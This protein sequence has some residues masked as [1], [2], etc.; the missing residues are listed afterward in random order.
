MEPNPNDSCDLPPL[1]RSDDHKED[2]AT[3]SGPFDLQLTTWR[4]LNSLVSFD[5][6]PLP[7]D[8]LFRSVP[9]DEELCR[10]GPTLVADYLNFDVS[11]KTD[12][13]PDVMTTM[14]S[15]LNSSTTSEPP[16]PKG[17]YVEPNYHATLSSFRLPMDA[18]TAVQHFLRSQSIDFYDC[19]AKYKLNCAAYFEGAKIPFKVR[20]YTISTPLKRYVI[21]F[22]RRSGN[23]LRFGEIY[24][25]AM[26]SL[27]DEGLLSEGF[28]VPPEDLPCLSSVPRPTLHLDKAPATIS[29]LLQMASSSYEDV[30]C[31]AL[32][33][34]SEISTEQALR[35]PQQILND[36]VLEAF[37]AYSN[38]EIEDARRCAVT[39]MANLTE[40]CDVLAK[41]FCHTL[42]ARGL[43]E[44]FCHDICK[45]DEIFTPQIMRETSRLLVNIAQ[46]VGARM[47]DGLDR[48]AATEA[49]GKLNL[50]AD[51]AVRKYAE[52]IGQLMRAPVAV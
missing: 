34:L 29:I 7:D 9:G 8:L 14:Y 39:G 45:S 25:L 44:Q 35:Q 32:R 12:S 2:D 18:L 4:S 5:G 31:E 1:S 26:L 43:V 23:T 38:S 37:I 22:Q 36:N 20:I 33:S 41:T 6:T 28:E 42:V 50:S 19:P 40:P 49:F 27:Y 16:A 13:V 10:S 52:R 11:G 15:D 3:L 24:R 47:Y 30:Q 48:E 46:S 51:P 21:E 17:G